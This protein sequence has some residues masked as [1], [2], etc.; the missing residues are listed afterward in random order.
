M[1]SDDCRV[2]YDS[3]SLKGVLEQYAQRGGNL[4][5]LM[6]VI[7]EDLVSSVISQFEAQAGHSQG[8]W[9]ELADSTIAARRASSSPQMLRDTDVLFGSITP[10]SGDDVAEAFTNVPYA[11]YHVSKEPRQHLPLRDF[12]DI[13][14]EGVSSRAIDLI[15][16]E[17]VT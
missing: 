11:K 9:Q 15:L 17:M 5:E 7:A 6:P 14:M 2:T 10:Y 13:D 12:L 8:P 1:A 16:A 3:T 4:A